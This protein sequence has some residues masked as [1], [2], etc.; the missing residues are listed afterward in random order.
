METRDKKLFK[1]TNDKDKIKWSSSLKSFLKRN[2]EGNFVEQDVRLTSHRPFVTQFIYFNKLLTHR[3]GKLLGIFPLVAFDP[4]NPTI[5]LPGPGNR[6]TFGVFVVANIPSLD[7]AFEKAQCF[8]FYTYPKSGPKHRENITSWALSE[9]RT[10]YA[11]KKITKWNIFHATYA[12]LHHP[13]YRTRYAANLKRELP[14]I[15]FPPDFHSFAAAG[16]RLMELHIDYEKQ[17]EYPLEHIE[18]PSKE[19][20][21]TY[22]VEKMRLNPKDR[23]ELRYNDFLTLRGIPA[24]AFD[25]RLGNRSALEWV[26]DQ[27]RVSVDARSGIRNDPNREDD[28]TYILRLIGQVITV[29]LETHQI[30]AAL[31]SLNLEPPHDRPSLGTRQLAHPESAP[32]PSGI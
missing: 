14:R 6:K 1:W 26:I 10:H 29:S 11:D 5:C 22:R 18:N 25:Y 16:Q 15:P 27:Y 31:P 23:S 3:R 9:F 32:P 30:I 7:F 28:P 4:Q 17:P 2:I 8:P 24:A 21:V 19:V 13:E 20:E 12:V